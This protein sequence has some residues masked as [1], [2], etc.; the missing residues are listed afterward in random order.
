[1]ETGMSGGREMPSSALYNSR[2]MQ[3]SLNK[4]EKTPD[5]YL[6]FTGMN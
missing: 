5:L 2:N 4:N 6:V 3:G 1:M